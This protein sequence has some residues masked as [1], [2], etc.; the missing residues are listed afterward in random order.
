MNRRGQNALKSGTG[1]ASPM[2]C[3]QCPQSSFRTSKQL[4]FH[5]LID[6]VATAKNNQANVANLINR[7]C[8]ALN[9]FVEGLLTCIFEIIYAS[10]Y[11]YFLQLA[12]P[13]PSIRIICR[14]V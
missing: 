6:S 12:S 5:D 13:D 7:Q 1:G 2:L 3:V 4:S 11:R 8:N 9:T 14:E 10:K